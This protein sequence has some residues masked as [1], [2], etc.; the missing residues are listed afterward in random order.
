MVY[1]IYQ[2][3]QISIPYLLKIGTGK[4]AKIGKYLRD[5]NM[6]DVAIF[7]GSGIEDLLGAKL[8]EGFKENKIKV[9]YKQ[10]VSSIAFEGATESAFALPEVDAILGI[11][12]GKALDVAKLIS[13][14]LKVPYISVPT[15]ISNDGFCSPLTSL[16]FDGVRKTIKTA[17]PFG[18]VIDLDVIKNSPD[19]ALYSGFGDMIS[20]I[21][22]LW[23]WKKAAKMGLAK[24][25]DFASL[26]AYNSLDLL[27]AKHLTDIHSEVFQKSLANSLLVSGI[28]MEIAGTSRPASGSEHLISHALDKVAKEPRAHGIQVGVATLLCALL[29]K[30][31]YLDTVRHALL[32]TGFVDFVSK[33]PLVKAEVIEALELA[34]AIKKNYYTVLSQKGVMEKALK[35]IAKDDLLA[36][37]IR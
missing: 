6:N 25:N 9:L 11:G 28:A 20:K 21:T 4:T 18:V 31:D 27:M 29:Q 16:T 17:I 24:Y 10:D 36:V 23:D 19:E 34:P 32:A 3:R 1:P 14:L 5:K 2:N 7:F 15:S 13:Y 8:Y 35:L 26:M 30:N 22:A 12:G 33:K 37:L